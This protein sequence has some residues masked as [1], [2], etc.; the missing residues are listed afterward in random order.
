MTKSHTLKN[1]YCSNFSIRI[2]TNT[3]KE[4][5][6]GEIHNAFYYEKEPIHNSLIAG[7][8]IVILEMQTCV[9]PLNAATYSRRGGRG[10]GRKGG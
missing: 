3:V 6:K 5:G 9:I 1:L 10:G 2:G 4:E 8:A 7:A